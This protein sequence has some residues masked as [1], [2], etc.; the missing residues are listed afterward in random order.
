MSLGKIEMSVGEGYGEGPM[1]ETSHT[2]SD[3][4]LRDKLSPFPS[5]TMQGN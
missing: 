4:S 2:Y 3:S 5:H 1:E